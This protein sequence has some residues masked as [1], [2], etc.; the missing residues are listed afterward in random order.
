MKKSVL[1]GILLLNLLFTSAQHLEI[2]KERSQLYITHK[3]AAKETLYSLGRVYHLSPK[4]IAAA[5]KLKTDAGLQIGQEVKIPLKKDNFTQGNIK[6]KKGLAPVYHTIQKG[7][8]LGKL[9]KN[10]NHV[11]EELLKKWNRIPKGVV[12]PGQELIVGYVKFNAS[13]A[14]IATVP[15]K[16]AKQVPS[17]ENVAAR[18]EDVNINVPLQEHIKTDAPTGLPKVAPVS[19]AEITPVATTIGNEGFFAADY[20]I[21]ATTAR[22]KKLGGSA[23]TFKSTS[24]WSDK[25]YYLLVNNVAP[26]TIVKITANGKSV[27][28][29]VL[30]SLPDL[31]DNK[32]IACRL[33]NAAASALGITDA[34]FDVEISFYE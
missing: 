14:T 22:E 13:A 24:G 6:S 34:K 1:L 11:K 29:K 31:K 17:R 30:E 25:K 28:A 5:N 9:S 26:E 3:V 18:Q 33:S 32:G 23:A 21:R 12:K 15:E 27:Y 19:V 8:N 10:Y 16:K 7:E 4:D 20:S 2:G